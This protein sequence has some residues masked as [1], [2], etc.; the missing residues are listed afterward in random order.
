MKKALTRILVVVM[1]LTV[2]AVPAYAA[3]RQEADATNIEAAKRAPQ[4][5]LIGPRIMKLVETYA[6]ELTD[7]FRDAIDEH[8]QLHVEI[9]E[10]KGEIREAYSEE[11]LKEIRKEIEKEM[12]EWIK[13]NG[14]K[15]N[16]MKKLF[17]DLKDAVEEGDGER[18]GE[19][20]EDVLDAFKVHITVDEHLIAL[21]NGWLQ[22]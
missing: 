6:P 16:E 11:E 14:N 15:K 10:L 12:K 13:E 22:E 9:R 4:F 5:R 17:R 20:L 8:R 19:L 7:D 18:I 21:L 2:V 1:V 3:V